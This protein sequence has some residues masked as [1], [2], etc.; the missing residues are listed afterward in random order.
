M[1]RQERSGVAVNTKSQEESEHVEMSENTQSPSRRFEEVNKAYFTV[2]RVLGI[3]L[4]RWNEREMKYNVQKAKF[5]ISYLFWLLLPMEVIVVA[6]VV[7]A[8]FEDFESTIDR[9]D[10]FVDSS[11]LLL[12]FMVVPA[13]QAYSLKLITHSLPSILKDI[14]DIQGLIR[15]GFTTPL[16][17][18]SIKTR[19]PEHLR[20]TEAGSKAETLMKVVPIVGFSL[21]ILIGFIIYIAT[22]IWITIQG[23]LTTE[24]VHLVMQISYLIFP[25]ITSCFSAG[26]IRWLYM[27][28]RELWMKL[29][30]IEDDSSQDELDVETINEISDYVDQLEKIFMD[31][32]NGFLRYVLAVNFLIYIIVGVFSFVKVINQ[33]PSYVIPFS[34]CAFYLV[35]ICIVSHELMQEVSAI[36][37]L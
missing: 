32:S 6:K 37:R 28:Y 24:W 29:K 8:L 35:L 17:V 30:Q 19:L 27:V 25:C 3:Y 20:P 23:D 31:L 34:V 12:G 4:I 26:F 36:E 21:S 16:M 15:T 13:F 7:S 33:Y 14:Y 2:F 5:C 1:M 22:V 10:A 11:L 18:L 9:V